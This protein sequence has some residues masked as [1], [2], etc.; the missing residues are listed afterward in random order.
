MKRFV[1]YR[2]I[3]GLLVFC[4]SAQYALGAALHCE[5]AAGVSSHVEEGSEH[6]DEAQLSGDEALKHAG[7]SGQHCV[8]GCGCLTSG[9]TAAVPVPDSH[10]GPPN[11]GGGLFER[12]KAVHLMPPTQLLRPPIDR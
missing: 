2:S 8:S 3:F 7:S 9:G 5:P 11:P 10:V 1:K 6:C 12:A 4:L